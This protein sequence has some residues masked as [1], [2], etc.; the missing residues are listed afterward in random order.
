[1]PPDSRITSYIDK[2]LLPIS[3]QVYLRAQDASA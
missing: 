2:N 1:M 3:V